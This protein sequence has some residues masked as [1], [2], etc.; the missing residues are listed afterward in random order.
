LSTLALHRIDPP[1]DAP[2]DNPGPPLPY[3]PF[4]VAELPRPLSTFVTEAAAA[5]GCAHAMVALPAIAAA[6]ALI[7]NSRTIRLNRRWQEPCVFWACVVAD[8][9]TLKSPALDMAVLP[10]HRLQERLKAEY[11]MRLDEYEANYELWKERKRHD[12]ANAG[13]EPDKP[14]MGRVVCSDI[15]VERLA[16]LLEQ[17]P[18]GLLCSRD[19]LAAWFASFTRYKGATG[20]SDLPT[21]LSMHRAGPLIVDRKTSVKQTLLIPRAAVSV[22]GTI[23][24]GILAKAVRGD[25]LD[26]GLVARLLLAMPPKQRKKWRDVDVDPATDEAYERLLDGLFRLNFGADGNGEH[27]PVVLSLDADA[28]KA[29]GIFYD[30]FAGEQADADGARAATLSKLEGYAARFALLHHVCE[31]VAAGLDERTPVRAQSV[32]AGINLARWFA[33]EAERVYATF[34]E[35]EAERGLRR[36]AE[37]IAARGGEV[38]VRSVQGSLRGRFPTAMDA[39]T[40]LDTL[41]AAGLGEWVRE[42][43]S[44]RG[45][46]PT[47]KFR[48]CAHKTGFVGG[49]VGASE[50]PKMPEKQGEN[51]VGRGFCGF[52][53]AESNPAVPWIAPG[54]TPEEVEAVIHTPF[55]GDGGR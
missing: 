6:G 19:E 7:G 40:A 30:D 54:L 3:V 33:R 31:H 1:A 34:A 51:E 52:V 38:T 48:L 36:L 5:I 44:P 46:R 47:E 43:S 2:R 21:W 41:A 23:Q 45:G 12:A 50:T 24:P 18:R 16:E 17:N 15:T 55:D 42:S 27:V 11:A 53:S 49:F 26:S 13:P 25:F 32:A 9:G 22:T 35:T 10:L 28:R 29:W 37:W 20:G 4:P 8:S 39:R 14:V